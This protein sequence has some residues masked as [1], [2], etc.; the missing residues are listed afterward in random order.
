MLTQ[1]RLYTQ[2]A[3]SFYQNFGKYYLFCSIYGMMNILY[4]LRR[5]L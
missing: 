5:S 1:S 2:A 4:T 3:F